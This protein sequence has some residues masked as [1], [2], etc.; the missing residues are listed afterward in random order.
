VNWDRLTLFSTVFVSLLSVGEQGVL[1][2]GGADKAAPLYGPD[3]LVID[4]N[5]THLKP[6]IYGSPRAWVV[7]FYSSW[8]GHCIHFAP[9][10]K[11]FAADFAGKK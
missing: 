9:K 3:D 5:V 4:L 11:Q 1:N 10:W 8:C 2:F 7:E 6:H